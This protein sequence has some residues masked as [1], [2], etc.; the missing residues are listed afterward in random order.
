MSELFIIILLINTSPKKIITLCEDKDFFFIPMAY[1]RSWARDQIQATA[2]TLC[3]AV[4]VPQWELH[5]FL[6]LNF[7]TIFFIALSFAYYRSSINVSFYR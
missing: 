7:F 6:N 5:Y 4:G 2:T 3:T 1:E